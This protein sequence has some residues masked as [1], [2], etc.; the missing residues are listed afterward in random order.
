MDLSITPGC[1]LPRAKATVQRHA[2]RSGITV[3]WS[4]DCTADHFCHELAVSAVELNPFCFLYYSTQR[5]AADDLAQALRTHLPEL[6]C[7]GCSTSGEISPDGMQQYGIMAVLLPARWFTVSTCVIE[8]IR[9]LRMHSIARRATSHRDD[10][11]A[12]TGTVE[13]NETLFAINLID[14][15]SYAEEAVASALDRGLNGIPLIG[16]SAGDDLQLE[17]TSQICNGRVFRD[18]AVLTLIKC[19]L[20]CQVFTGNNFVP[21]ESKLVVT[22]SDISRR[23]VLEINGEPAGI[24]YARSLGVSLGDLTIECFASNPMVVRINGEH[25][26]RSIQC[27]NDDLSLTFFCAVDNGLVLT[28]ARAEGMLDATRRT[29]ERIEQSIGALDL[30]F[31]F[32]CIHRKLDA[33]NRNSISRISELY[34]QKHFIGCNT[35]GEQFHAMHLNQTFTGVAIG[36]PPGAR[37]A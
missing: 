1:A 15:L 34:R 5:Y 6:A 32:D 18:A 11:L 23:R 25:Y 3:L 30:L 19:A 13:G 12:R 36:L 24:A 16:G 14:G 8:S 10:F 31:G 22:D 7:C 21:T 4:T 26:C 33:A 17:A 20:P 27:V 35:Y 28:L 2:Y 29:I 37:P 9:S